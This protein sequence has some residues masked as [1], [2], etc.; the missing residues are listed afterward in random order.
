MI[1]ETDL[2]PTAVTGEFSS[3]LGP[4]HPDAQEGQPFELVIK[5][6]YPHV[7]AL[8]D[9][10]RAEL[11]IASYHISHTNHPVRAGGGRETGRVIIS[12]IVAR[13]EARNG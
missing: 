7:T 8:F 10:I 12:R 6:H 4:L 11:P 3:H 9:R 5:G 2:E 13:L 1:N